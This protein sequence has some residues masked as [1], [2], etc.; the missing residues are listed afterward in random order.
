[1][2][3]LLITPCIEHCG[4]VGVHTFQSIEKRTLKRRIKE[5]LALEQQFKT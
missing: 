3:I 1:M 2:L 4:Y 5:S